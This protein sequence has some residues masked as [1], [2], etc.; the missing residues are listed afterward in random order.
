[1]LTSDIDPF[2]EPHQRKVSTLE[3][4]YQKYIDGGYIYPRYDKASNR[5]KLDTSFSDIFID[6]KRLGL[7]FDDFKKLLQPVQMTIFD[8]I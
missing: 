2:D 8:F 1:M 3:D 6:C 4:I 7:S 5:A